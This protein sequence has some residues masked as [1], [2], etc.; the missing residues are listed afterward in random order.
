MKV[1]INLEPMETIRV[2]GYH[3]KDKIINEDFTEA[4]VSGELNYYHTEYGTL[5]KIPLS[6]K[7]WFEEESDRWFLES[8]FPTFE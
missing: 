3:I 5:K 1:D 8:D 2:T 4:S 7:W 6:Q